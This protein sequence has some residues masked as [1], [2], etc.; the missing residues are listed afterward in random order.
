M[1]QKQL[2]PLWKCLKQL[3]QSDFQ[4]PE[5]EEFFQINHNPTH[6]FEIAHFV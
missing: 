4:G 1:I 3:Y 2:V 5:P 6:A